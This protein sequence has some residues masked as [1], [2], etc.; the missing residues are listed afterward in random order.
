VRIAVC[1]SPCGN[2][3]GSWGIDD[4]DTEAGAIEIAREHCLENESEQ[5]SAEAIITAHI[6]RRRIPVVTGTVEA[7]TP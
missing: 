1:V 5:P 3:T 2:I 4:G 6:P 7:V